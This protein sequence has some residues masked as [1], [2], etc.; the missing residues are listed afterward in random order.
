MQ[1]RYIVLSV[2]GVLILIGV[3]TGIWYE[4][5]RSDNTSITS[6]SPTASPDTSGDLSVIDGSNVGQLGV[7][8]A[9]DGSDNDAKQQLP[10]PEGFKEY[11][12]YVDD[13]A[14]LYADIVTGTGREA[15]AGDS[16]AVVYQGWLTD[17]TLFDQT[18]KNEK[19]QLVAFSFTL[20]AGQVI[21]GWEQG[22]AG[23]KEGGKR[24]IIVP[25]A[26]AYGDKG[27]GPIPPNS[28]LVFDV[29]L[30]Q[31]EEAKA[32]LPPSGL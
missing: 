15:Q 22:L 6:R 16:L 24:R 29:E 8:G 20:G 21:P 2:V 7:L 28:L 19:G 23:M 30:F 9:N 14:A 10:G 27:Q 1:T 5:S 31:L 32:Q 25:P 26:L 18:T 4:S 17:G 13:T 11:E 3:G 12:Q